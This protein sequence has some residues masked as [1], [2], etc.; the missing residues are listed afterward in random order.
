MLSKRMEA[1]L[2]NLK[3]INS[4]LYIFFTTLEYCLLVIFLDSC[5]KPLSCMLIKL[6]IGVKLTNDVK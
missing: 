4:K 5:I 1:I 2:F 3:Y 6:E